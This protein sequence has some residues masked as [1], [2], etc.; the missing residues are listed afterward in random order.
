MQYFRNDLADVEELPELQDIGWRYVSIKNNQEE[1]RDGRMAN[2]SSDTL[3]SEFFIWPTD[4][5]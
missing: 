3:P 5:F 2:S 4:N 1:N